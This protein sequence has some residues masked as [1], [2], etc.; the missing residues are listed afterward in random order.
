MEKKEEK[1][2]HSLQIELSSEVAEGSCR[3]FIIWHLLYVYNAIHRSDV[4]Q[5]VLVY[6]FDFI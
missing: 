2:K 5:L 3:N 6:T 1:G 4:L